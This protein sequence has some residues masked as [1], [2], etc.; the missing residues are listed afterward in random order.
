[1]GLAAGALGAL[2]MRRTIET[3]LFGVHADDPGTFVTV[4][5]TLAIVSL[6][7]CTV[8]AWRAGRIDPLLALR[9]E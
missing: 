2:A 5:F 3:I 1:V 7:A 8:P 4:M 9:Q 6:L